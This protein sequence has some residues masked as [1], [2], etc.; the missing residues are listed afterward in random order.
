[1]GD[2][3]LDELVGFFK[4]IVL[5]VIVKVIFFSQELKDEATKQCYSKIVLVPGVFY[6]LNMFQGYK[7]IGQHFPGRCNIVRVDYIMGYIK[8]TLLI[9]CI[10]MLLLLLKY[11]LA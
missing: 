1:M 2:F 6:G 5:W 10:A 11:V 7:A 8:L 3:A 4:R 9:T